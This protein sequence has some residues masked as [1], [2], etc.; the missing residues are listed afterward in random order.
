MSPRTLRPSFLQSPLLPQGLS[1][2]VQREAGALVCGLVA[3]APTAAQ[4]RVGYA[5][6][7]C[8]ELRDAVF[9]LFQ[10][11]EPSPAPELAAFRAKLEQGVRLALNRA[12]VGVKQGQAGVGETHAAARGAGSGPS[13]PGAS[14]GGK[15]GAGSSAGGKGA[16]A[17]AA[18]ASAGAQA[19][20][21]GKGGSRAGPA[22]AKP[23]RGKGG[24]AE[25][26]DASA[27]RQNGAGVAATSANAASWRRADVEVDAPGVTGGDGAGRGADAPMNGASATD[28]DKWDKG[29]GS[30]AK[31]AGVP[32]KGA[33]KWDNGGDAWTKGAHLPVKGT[34]AWMKGA[35]SP[36]KGEPVEGADTWIKGADGT[37]KGA[38]KWDKGAGSPVKGADSPI[39][40][41]DQWVKG[42]DSPI[43]GA[44][45]WAKGDGAP[46]KGADVWVK[47]AG[48]PAKGADA[49][50]WRNGNAT[51]PTA[52]TGPGA[53]SW[54]Q[55][56]ATALTPTPRPHPP[57]SPGPVKPAPPP[58]P[59]RQAPPFAN[60][61][62]AHWGADV[63]AHGLTRA[64]DAQQLREREDRT[65]LC[66]GLVVD[67]VA[68]CQQMATLAC[69]SAESAAWVVAWLGRWPGILASDTP[70][71][72]A[73]SRHLRAALAPAQI[74]QASQAEQQA[75]V[76]LAR[77]LTL[78]TTS[79]AEG[80]RRASI[81]SPMPPHDMLAAVLGPVL[82]D[83]CEQASRDPCRALPAVLHGLLPCLSICRAVVPALL[84]SPAD[85][86]KG[87]GGPSAA[88]GGGAGGAGPVSW[89]FGPLAAVG[90]VALSLATLTAMRMGSP[91]AGRPGAPLDTPQGEASA[92]VAAALLGQCLAHYR[93][94]LEVPAPAVDEVAEVAE[95]AAA[96]VAEAEVD[97]DGVSGQSLT[98]M[99]R[100]AE[101]AEGVLC[102]F[103]G[104]TLDRDTHGPQDRSKES[105]E[106]AVRALR[107]VW[108]SCVKAA[109]DW[110][111]AVGAECAV[112]LPS[113]VDW[114]VVRAALV[115]TAS[116]L[117]P[118][119]DEMTV[120]LH[121][122]AASRKNAKAI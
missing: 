56:P 122:C 81:A 30:P 95:V 26:A 40:G 21:P 46:V 100:A 120:P 14:K 4:D 35:G 32:A 101:V 93:A 49:P 16:A 23:G 58:G 54:R 87:A 41:A 66:L 79:V 8:P 19:T 109:L 74:V 5:L 83:E 114:R 17:A 73:V 102:P 52:A 84:G 96:A 121:A 90:D 53:L 106:A 51:A 61:D 86:S 28:A 103:D 29:A 33:D 82:R 75:V 77:G 12:S 115:T 10:A 25:R 31:G 39:K 2:E 64:N 85:G 113:G 111:P 1:W 104:V 44:D 119:W 97:T 105:S 107:E 55:A 37:A 36:V 89:V 43:K 67:P 80:G 6:G 27:R 20:G 118:R 45:V 47:S 112:S 116:H 62:S 69:Q 99:Q 98:S 9:W 59:L 15:G 18:A 22:G 42:A 60:Q 63:S 65:V 91:A 70:A 11:R 24:G 50:S 110:G 117:M 57:T 68:T 34:D 108:A 71:G 13:G 88:T 94:S 72:E 7:S 78:G 38:D 92:E 48:V 3:G 76:R